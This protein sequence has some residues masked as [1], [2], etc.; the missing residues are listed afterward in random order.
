MRSRVYYRPLPRFSHCFLPRL[1]LIAWMAFACL[2]LTVRLVGQDETEAEL[3]AE[4]EPE[5]EAELSDEQIEQRLREKFSNVEGL[6]DVNLKV[7]GGVAV[8]SG[9]VEDSSARAQAAEIAAAQQGV[10]GV[11]NEVVLGGKVSERI[12]SAFDRSKLKLRML[13]GYLPLLIAAIAIIAISAVLARW[14]AR[15]AIAR[16]LVGRNRFLVEVARQC[17]RLGVLLAG[18][19]I[20][21]DLL[22]ATAMVG[23]VFGAAG[24]AGLAIGFAFKD[25]IENYVSSVLLSLRR[26]F[27]P[28]DHVV[29]D[30]NEGLV[31]SMNTRATTL[32]TLEG[33]H[34][35]LPNAL[36]FKSVMLN[37]TRNSERRFDFSVGV[38]VGEDLVAAQK[39][40]VYTL[41]SME[42]VLKDPGP[43][44]LITNLAESSVTILFI[45]WV[46][47]TQANYG[48]V[49][50]EAIRLV[51]HALEKEGM[52][53]P[54]PIYRVKLTGPLHQV[55]EE[56]ASR[57]PPPPERGTDEQGDVSLDPYLDRQVAEEK[58]R[59]ADTDLLRDDAPHE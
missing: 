49:K 1:L 12:G 9:E 6:R 48:K 34:L 8:I 43:L 53:L 3:A 37:Y 21:L 40:G 55:E 57:K 14:I 26:P 16:R 36:V 45:G 7:E 29:I 2:L 4:P 54:E 50:G 18:V 46:N 25:L 44:A 47:Q 23:A 11:K 38:G 32:M 27:Q 15:P 39:I 31:V 56:L 52:D 28:N 10:V 41:R 58:R 59:V 51:K 30:G 19:L 22:D 33:N 20:A 42:G 17:I 5:A 13:V 35:R 24:L